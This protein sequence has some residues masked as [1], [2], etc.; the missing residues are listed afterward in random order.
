LL[1]SNF[2]KIVLQEFQNKKVL[3]VSSRCY[4]GLICCIVNKSLPFVIPCISYL[5]F[6][7]A[8]TSNI[9]TYLSMYIFTTGNK[10]TGIQHICVFAVC[11][12]NI[13]ISCTFL[14]PFFRHQSSKLLTFC[15]NDICVS[16]LKTVWAAMY[17]RPKIHILIANETTCDVLEMTPNLQKITIL[18]K[19]KK[20]RCKLVCEFFF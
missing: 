8:K 12:K 1:P 9:F 3:W 13:S 2:F 19:Y 15:E 18:H 10:W 7:Q 17:F 5:F 16:F 20:T 11:L 6:L 4:L 14:S